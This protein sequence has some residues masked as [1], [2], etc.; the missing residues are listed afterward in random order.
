M[1]GKKKEIDL[2]EYEVCNIK[3][4]MGFMDANRLLEEGWEPF[5]TSEGYEDEH[6]GQW[7]IRLWL[8]RITP[9]EER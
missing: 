1:P 3:D 8:R 7:A 2:W 9:I 6:K 4:D 5:A